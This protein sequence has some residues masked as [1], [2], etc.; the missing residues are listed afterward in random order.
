MADTHGAQSTSDSR[1]SADSLS[2]R[3]G[4][5]GG[6]DGRAHRE[7]GAGSGASEK[8]RY[9]R[10]RPEET[11]LYQVVEQHVEP[12]F[13]TIAEQGTSLPEFVR[14]Q[15]D[16]YLDC[17]RL[18]KGFIRAKCSGCRYEHLVAFSCKL[19]GFCPSC[20]VRRMVESAAHLL[21][22]VV[23]YV[24]MRQ[25]V[26]S[27]PWPLRVL[28]AARPDWLSRILGIVTRALSSAVIRS[29][30]LCRGQGAQTGTI[31]F[32]QRHGSALNLNVHFHLLVPD[33]AYTFEHGKPHF[34]RAPAPSSE[35]LHRLLDTLITRITRALVRGGVLVE[36]PDQ[37]LP[38]P[39]ARL[40]T[41]AAQH[42]RRAIPYRRGPPGRSQNDDLTQPAHRLW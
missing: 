28:F 9:A 8:R 20:G 31:T 22:H 38:R 26:L 13:R 16:A 25:W 14:A 2:T 42:C 3:L 36:E 30:A 17:G 23:P 5:N 40:A 35:Q 10:H 7:P 6:M 39:G 1:R 34:H 24:P 15:F 29:A 21:D 27:V 33:G 4:C 41:G 32:V 37:A 19:R 18:E 11:V 12:F